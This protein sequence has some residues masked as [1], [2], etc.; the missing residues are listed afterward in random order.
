M[1][2]DSPAAVAPAREYGAEETSGELFGL[3]AKARTS[4]IIGIAQGILVARYG[5]PG[6]AAAFALLRAGSQHHNVPLR[7]LA[8]AVVTAPPP[9]TA[10]EWFPGRRHTAPPFGALEFAEAAEIHLSDAV[11][12]EALLMEAHHGLD[13]AYRDCLALVTGPPAVCARARAAGRPVTVP[14]GAADPEL[15]GHAVGRAALAAGSRVLYATPMV[16][17]DGG[18][19]G[20]ICVHRSEPGAWLAAGEAA[21]L[22]SLARDLAAWRSW[23][24]RTVVQDALEYLHAHGPAGG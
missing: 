22:D 9:R 20:V 16:T 4:G 21:A 1:C 23:Y 12:D 18:C 17:E 15:A 11:Q 8:S 2:A 24:R 10:R 5:L 14:D 7:L 19:S 3:R 13:A 6:P